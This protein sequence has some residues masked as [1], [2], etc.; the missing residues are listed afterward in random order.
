MPVKLLLSFAAI[1][2][3]TAPVVAK[4]KNVSVPANSKVA[5]KAAQCR[6]AKGHFAK[7]GSANA[8]PTNPAAVIAGNPGKVN[9]D[10]NGRCHVSEGPK[11]GQ[12]TACPKK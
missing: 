1:A 6:D 8:V 11:K 10:K 7:C 2:L 12:F 3:M 5:A 4:D 9:V